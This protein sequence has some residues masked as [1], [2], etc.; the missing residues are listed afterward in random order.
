MY[1]YRKTVKSDVSD[2]LVNT[3]LLRPVAG[4]LVR[5]LYP[6]G[7]T[8]NQVTIASTIAGLVGALVYLRGDSLSVAIGGLLVT[9]KDVLDSADGQLARAKQLYSRLGRFLDSIGDFA[10]NVGVFAAIGWVLNK[11]GGGMSYWLLTLFGLT[12]ITFRVSYQ[13]F[14]QTSYLH[15]AQKYRLNR[16]TEEVRTEDLGADR[17]TLT[18][19]KVFLQIYG[20]QDRLV[21]RIDEWCRA[22]RD[23]KNLINRW[24]S[25]LTGLRLA[26]FIGMGTE[27]FLLTVCSLV[28]RLELYLYL[29]AVLM[30]S[31]L[32]VNVAYRRVTLRKKFS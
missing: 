1:D 31:V 23:D 32:A 15:L 30:N 10:V 9:M 8:P 24:Y 28:N 6:T 27:L 11:K 7:I 25:D 19:Q 21:L 26:G 29:N 22:G 3:Y 4:L 12:G 5:L 16:T 20:W 18:L 14:Y 2:E 17:T 13:V